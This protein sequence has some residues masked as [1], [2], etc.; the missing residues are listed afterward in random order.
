MSYFGGGGHPYAA[1]FRVYE[2][3]D[4]IVRELVEATS[5]ALEEVRQN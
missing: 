1:G 3:Y 4:Q 2:E 5:R